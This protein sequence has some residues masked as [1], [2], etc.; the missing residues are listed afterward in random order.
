MGKEII[1]TYTKY[2]WR[3]PDNET[4]ILSFKKKINERIKEFMVNS[5]SV[6]LVGIKGDLLYDGVWVILFVKGPD[7]LSGINS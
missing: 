5:N 4:E 2:N 7:L 3:N 1:P 6:T